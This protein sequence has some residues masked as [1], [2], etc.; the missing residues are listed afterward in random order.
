MEK[1][2][3]AEARAVLDLGTQ[4]SVAVD[5][6]PCDVSQ[7]SFDHDGQSVELTV[8]RP[9]RVKSTL[10]VFMFFYGEAG[11]WGTFRRTNASSGTWSPVPRGG[12]LRELHPVS[13]SP[14]S[15]RDQPGL[16]RDEV[17]GRVRLHAESRQPAAGGCR[18]QRRRQ[19]GGSRGPH[20]QGPRRTADPA[21]GPDVAVTDASF[22]TGS[23]HQY[24]EG[25][26]LTR[27]MMK[28]FWDH[29]TTDPQERAPKLCVAAPR[30]PRTN[31][32]ASPA[33][34]FRSRRTM[35][36]ATKEA[37]ARRLNEA[38]VDVTIVRYDGLIHDWGLLNPLAK[39]PAVRAA[40]RQVST[41]L[42]RHL[43]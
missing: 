36:S 12:G 5:L 35:S 31:S 1:M 19:H 7:V 38:G 20:G 34:R 37:Y 9:A 41:E 22:E 30:A 29:C 39:V 2:S 24:A 18:E 4:S 43:Q 14:L 10:P 11:S 40:L 23:Y 8:V 28:W 26:F 27:N 33:A 17:G 6:P 32:A 3:P 13:G 25:R 42:R 16:R 15:R 21:A